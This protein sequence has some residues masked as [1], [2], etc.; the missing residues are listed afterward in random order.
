MYRQ[1]RKQKPFRGHTLKKDTKILRKKINNTVFKKLAIAFAIVIV[2]SS[3]YLKYL[4]PNTLEAKQRIQ[5]ESTQTQ[6]LETVQKLEQQ[7]SKTEEQQR[8]LDETNKKLQE[9]EQQLRAKRNVQIALAERQPIY[10]AYTGSNA[11]L[12]AAAGIPES[13][14]AGVEKIYGQ[15]SGVCHLKWQGQFGSCPTH[16]VE[17]YPGA[18]SDTS[19]GYGIC[20][21]TPAIKMASE[22]EDWRTNPVTQMKWCYKYTLNYGSVQAAINF[23][24]CLGSC[25]SP[26]TNSTVWKST[27]WF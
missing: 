24:Y 14:W 10:A 5:L 8:L 3:L 21:S 11:E 1:T 15:E 27:P 17:K 19:I 22:G 23:K 7:Q 2:A 26:R 18:E 6:L 9:T 13:D 20:Q 12:Y 25:Y 16:Y 4:A